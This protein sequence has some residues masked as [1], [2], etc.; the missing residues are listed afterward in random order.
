LS[1][2]LPVTE[3][4]KR[5][6]ASAPPAPSLHAISLR[7]RLPSIALSLRPENPQA[8][9]CIE[10]GQLPPLP[11]LDQYLN[12]HSAP[13][14]SQPHPSEM[15]EPRMIEPDDDGNDTPQES[16]ADLVFPTHLS[17]SPVSPAPSIFAQFENIPL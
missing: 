3:P 12:N 11:E 4:P 14:V 16:G 7:T 9:H 6:I 10:L 13:P 17:L 1:L 2:G 15:F 5:D 8:V